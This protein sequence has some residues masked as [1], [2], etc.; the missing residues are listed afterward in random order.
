MNFKIAT[1][2][3]FR[4]EAKRLT[5]KYKSLKQEIESLGFQLSQNHAIGIAP[6]I[7]CFKIRLSIASK[8]KGKSDGACVITYSIAK[9][10]T[11]YLLSIF[12]KSEKDNILDAEIQELIHSISKE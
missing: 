3:G 10:G 8:N 4:K 11:V 7:N 6:G 12:D 1:I 2:T 9:D 5:K